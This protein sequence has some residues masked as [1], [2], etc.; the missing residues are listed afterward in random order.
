MLR[1]I[2]KQRIFHEPLDYRSFLDTLR[3]YRNLCGF[4]LYAWCLMPNHVHLLIGES[5]QGESISQIMKRIGT[6]YV[7]RYNLRYERIG[8]LFQDRFRSEA[9]KDDA[10]FLT[11]LRYIHLNPLKAGLPGGLSNYPH[12]SYASYL[13]EDPAY[14]A[15]TSK[16]Y[17]LID[18]SEYE[19]W[20]LQVDDKACLDLN[21]KANVRG[22]TDE[23]ALVLMNKTAGA[24]N[25]EDFQKL[26]EARQS[27]AIMRMRKS[28]ASLRQI[29]RLSGI[30]MARVRKILAA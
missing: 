5:P 28:G 4:Q 24:S 6:K 13:A 16:L 9:V 19:A 7:Y 14:P 11:V 20:H 18:R 29:S 10:H 12:S 21:D 3:V 1:G 27:K 26:P 17:S 15:D 22:I 8:P 30:S 2:N 25:A 23:R